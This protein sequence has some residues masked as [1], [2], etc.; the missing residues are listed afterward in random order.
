MKKT[1]SEE[2]QNEVN[3]EEG[4]RAFFFPREERTIFARSLAEATDIL[5]KQTA[6]KVETTEE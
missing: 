1:Q 6:E 4:K 2:V 5:A 3:L